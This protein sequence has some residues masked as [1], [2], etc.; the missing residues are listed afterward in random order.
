[1][2]IKR[3]LCVIIAPGLE[4]YG[5][6]IGTIW[7]G[8]SSSNSESFHL[9]NHPFTEQYGHSYSGAVPKKFLTAVTAGNDELLKLVLH[10]E[11]Q[12]E[13]AKLM[14]LTGIPPALQTRLITAA[15]EL[16]PDGVDTE[17]LRILFSLG[18]DLSNG[19]LNADA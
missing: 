6:S 8:Q 5:L 10:R 2:P 4:P 16:F 19:A 18:C 13:Q 11:K 17:K 14:H 9:F 7:W 3:E 1:M 12:L 15:N